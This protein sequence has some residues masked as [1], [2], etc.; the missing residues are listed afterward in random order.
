MPLDAFNFL[1]TISLEYNIF[2][3]FLVPL[4]K[5]LYMDWRDSKLQKNNKYLR[6]KQ[7]HNKLTQIMKNFSFIGKYFSQNGKYFSHF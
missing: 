5:S 3:I 6:K 7:N 2:D 4:L 1:L